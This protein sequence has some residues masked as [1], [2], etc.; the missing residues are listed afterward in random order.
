VPLVR[1]ASLACHRQPHP[2]GVRAET[3][4][5]YVT[6]VATHLTAITDLYGAVFTEPPYAE[7]PDQIRH[8]AAELLALSERGDFDCITAWHEDELV[9]FIYAIT[10]PGD[11]WFTRA[12]TPIPRHLAGIDRCFIIDWGVRADRRGSGVGGTLMRHLLAERPEQ[13]AV[14]SS[15]PESPAY[16]LY[17]RAGWTQVGNTVPTPTNPRPPMNIL[18]L[19]LR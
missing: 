18:H 6:R 7:T 13:H 16:Q 8:F 5:L 10:Q 17:L 2:P 12:T 3:F 11:R 4:L 19:P 9:G 1:L 14:L 15:R